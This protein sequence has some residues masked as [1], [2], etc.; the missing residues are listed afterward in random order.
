MRT[1]AGDI[2]EL[3]AVR[4]QG[5]R[6]YLA[7]QG[8]LDVPVYLGSRST[9]ILGKFGGHAGRA[10]RCGDVVPFAELVDIPGAESEL[11]PTLIPPLAANW[12]MGVLY[13]P[14]GAPDFFTR[15]DIEMFF[16]TAWKVHYGPERMG[17][18]RVYI[19]RIFMTTLTLWG[20]WI[21]PAICL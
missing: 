7:V 18:K 14:H 16:S 3:G 4:G 2:L 12:S 17:V 9:F 20:R 8:G 21:L 15:A 5:C 11:P 10:L 6:A 1:Q 19:L 13:G